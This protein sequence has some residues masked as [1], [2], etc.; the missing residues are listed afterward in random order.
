MNRAGPF[1]KN[2]SPSDMPA[3]SLTGVTFSYAGKQ[4][5]ENVFLEIPPGEFVA[6]L[7]PNG[8][9]KTTFL[10][11]VLGL[12]KP[13]E[14][15]V[16]VFGRPPEKML[17]KI[18][19]VPQ[20]SMIRPDFPAEVLDIVLTG[21]VTSMRF[22]WKYKQEEKDRAREALDSVGML[23]REHMRFRDLSGG[24]R[25]RILIARALL[26]G[27]KI[28]LLDEPT[29]NIDPQGKFCFFHFL[30]GLRDSITIVIV[31]HDMGILASRLTS[32]ACVNQ[33]IIHNPA[34]ELTPE[35][36]SLLYGTHDEKTCPA[37]EFFRTSQGILTKIR[38][39]R[40]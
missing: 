34:P 38:G 10:K 24:Q 19:Y 22:G 2:G 1:E 23:G 4:V 17:P 31:S 21:A 37:G 8:G 5:L 20:Q 40:P 33:R 18:G 35:M 32:I 7:G 36:M 3:L 28:L 12:L 14:G 29:S 13:D 9:G 39:G 11:I 6:I 25:Q 27:P 30:E 16:R 26:S 15:A